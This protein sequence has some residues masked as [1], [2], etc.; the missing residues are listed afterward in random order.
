MRSIPQNIDNTKIQVKNLI[1]TPI[2]LKVNRGRNKIELIEGMIENA[3]PQIFTIRS[4]DGNLS[5]FSYSDIL[6][7]NITF[8]ASKH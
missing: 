2:R 5:S 3:Y 7:N 1:G 6:A 4:D 8:H